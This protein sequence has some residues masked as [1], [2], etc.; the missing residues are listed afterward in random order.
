MARKGVSQGTPPVQSHQQV[1]L[2]AAA[3]VRAAVLCRRSQTRCCL[4][5]KPEFPVRVSRLQSSLDV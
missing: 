3:L 5:K 4:L 2:R 1:G